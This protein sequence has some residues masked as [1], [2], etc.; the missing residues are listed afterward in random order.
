[1][2][3]S[4]RPILSTHLLRLVMGDPV[5]GKR[6]R[7]AREELGLSQREFGERVGVSNA[8]TVSNW[9]RGV[10]D[11]PR[12]RLL[13]IVEATRKPMAYYLDVAPAPVVVAPS[14]LP[15]DVHAELREI[16]SIVE[17]LL[18]RTDQQDREAS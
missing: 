5:I 14:G 18:R 6:I 17:E 10:S 1:M 7:A 9:E 3:V 4:T 16:R 12:A 11:V 2:K 15:E 13:K 8:Q